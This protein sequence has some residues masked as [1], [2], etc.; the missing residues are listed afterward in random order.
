M[1]VPGKDGKQGETWPL[2]YIYFFFVVSFLCVSFF[3]LCVMSFFSVSYL[4]SAYRCWQKQF[5]WK[6]LLCYHLT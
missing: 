1:I 5:D 2:K 3:F 6:L 4:C